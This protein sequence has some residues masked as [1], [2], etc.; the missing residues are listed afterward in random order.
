VTRGL[1]L[2]FAIVGTLLLASISFLMTIHQPWL[3]L[4]A[5]LVTILFIG[6][7]FVVKVRMRRKNAEKPTGS[8]S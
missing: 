7:G 5:S 6:F 1:A 2:L 3:V 4:I 8:N